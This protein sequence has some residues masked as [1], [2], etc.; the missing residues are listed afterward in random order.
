VINPDDMSMDDKR[1]VDGLPRRALRTPLASGLTDL[2]RARS[3]W[4]SSSG[5]SGAGIGGFLALHGERLAR[6]GG[7]ELRFVEL[8]LSRVSGLDWSSVAYQFS[9]RDTAGKDRFADFV[10][11]GVSGR[12]VAIEVDGYDKVGRGGGMSREEF[13]DWLIRQNALILAGFTVLRFSNRRVL[14]DPG[15]CAREIG[16]ALS[17]DGSASVSFSNSSV[18]PVNTLGITFYPY[19]GPTMAAFRVFGYF[20]YALGIIFV[21][22]CLAAVGSVFR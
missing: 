1:R 21:L 5:C 17:C 19:D 2:D 20:Y 13:D 22:A 10:V 7:G 8:A 12:R 6:D 18:Q 9:F 3:G 4:S 15:G 11:F 14:D 16:S